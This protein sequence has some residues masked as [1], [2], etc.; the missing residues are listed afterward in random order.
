MTKVKKEDNGDCEKW[1][2]I[3]GTTVEDKR[4][5]WKKKKEENEGNEKVILNHSNNIIILD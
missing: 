2:S 3:N 4:I 1:R 5:R